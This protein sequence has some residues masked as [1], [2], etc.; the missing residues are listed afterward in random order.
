MPYARPIELLR[1]VRLF[2]ELF[3]RIIQIYHFLTCAES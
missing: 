3:K 1:L 2:F